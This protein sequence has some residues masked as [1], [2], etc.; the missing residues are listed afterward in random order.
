MPDVQ[1]LKRQR[2]ELVDQMRT[3]HDGA[4]EREDKKMTSEEEARFSQ[5]DSEVRAFDTRIGN[6]ERMAELEANTAKPIDA[7]A[8]ED[9]AAGE[10]F[11]N[12]ADYLKEVRTNPNSER[13]QRVNVNAEERTLTMGN[14]ASIGYVIPPEFDTAIRSVATQGS[15]FRPRSAKSPPGQNP[16][17]ETKYVALDQTGDKGILGG[18]NVQW[19]G[20]AAAVPDA[21]TPSLVQLGLKPK[22]LTAKIPVS[23]ELMNNYDALAEF[24]TERFTAAITSKEEMAFISGN[25]VFSPTGILGHASALAIDRSTAGSITYADIVAMYTNK[26]PGAGYEWIASG[27]AY[28]D[29]LKLRDP[30]NNLIWQQSARDDVP[31][32]ILGLPLNESARTPELGTEGDLMLVNLNP[33]YRIKDGSPLAIK[34]NPYIQ[35]DN[36]VTMVYAFWHVDGRPMLTGPIKNEN[37]A[38]QS[39]FVILS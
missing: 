14:D 24:L 6:E 25:G 26:L 19:V 21:G 33:Y 39:P 16:D 32:K 13:I 29:L 11:K 31:I 34:F 30:A 7:R 28:A 5:L 15:L 17:A 35:M 38:V 8:G 4:E 20:E 23:N 37:G 12:F 36:D 22:K 2:A 9:R 1:K 10:P 3:L 18:V 27:T